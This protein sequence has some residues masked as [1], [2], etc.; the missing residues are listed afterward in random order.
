MNINMFSILFLQEDQK[1]TRAG[2]A[3]EN[4]QTA[5]NAQE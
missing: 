4:I 2:E 1:G 3:E 5:T